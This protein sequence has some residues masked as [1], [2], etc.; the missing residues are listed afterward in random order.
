MFKQLI[1]HQLA[2]LGEIPGIATVGYLEDQTKIVAPGLYLEFAFADDAHI[3]QANQIHPAAHWVVHCVVADSDSAQQSGAHLALMVMTKLSH[4]RHLL[5]V[6]HCNPL[7]DFSISPGGFS[8]KLESYTVFEVH[9]ENDMRLGV[10]YWQE[11]VANSNFTA[12]YAY[13]HTDQLATPGAVTHS[14]IP[15]GIGSQP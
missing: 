12:D 10:D 9:Y 5:G 8:E 7:R 15:G 4:H 2:V 14:P 3:D 11:L 1:D 6:P 13:I